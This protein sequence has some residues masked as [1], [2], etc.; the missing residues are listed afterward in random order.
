MDFMV[1][2]REASWW[3]IYVCFRGGLGQIPLIVEGKNILN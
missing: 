3:K 1:T 2:D